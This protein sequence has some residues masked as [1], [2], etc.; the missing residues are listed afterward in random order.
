MKLSLCLVL[1]LILIG[2][3]EA[4]PE[5]TILTMARPAKLYAV[6]NTVKPIEHQLFARVDNRDSLDLKFEVSGQ[7]ISLPIRAGQSI[8]KGELI[9][10]LDAREHKLALDYANTS[11]SLATQE[12]A[13]MEKLYGRGMVSKS[14]FDEASTRHKLMRI[15]LE[16]AKEVVRDSQILAPFDGIVLQRLKQNYGAV[17]AGDVIARLTRSDTLEL[18]TDLPEILLETINQQGINSA[19]ARFTAHP[20]RQWPL[21]W[22]EQHAQISPGMPVFETRFILDKLPHW[23][24]L[25]GM[26]AQIV[27][28]LTPTLQQT[29]VPT[30]A[31]QADVDGSFFV[32]I[33]SAPDYTVNK[34]PVDVGTPSPDWVPVIAG[35]THG[36]TVIAAGGSSLREGDKILPLHSP[37]IR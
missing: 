33:T 34:R 30:A 24:P 6:K 16:Q 1:Y 29:L 17:V 11:L 23:Q 18:V 20:D 4:S 13:R 21:T 14:T 32:W 15:D 25:Q 36:D 28:Q 2:C 7:L 22:V 19:Y 27:L 12:L 35:L 9:A 8:K 31:L 10:A 26:T 37:V 5:Q 3:N